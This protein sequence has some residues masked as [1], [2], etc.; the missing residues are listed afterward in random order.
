VIKDEEQQ[1][2]SRHTHKSNRILCFHRP[3]KTFWIILIV[4]LLVAAAI[5]G[6][7]GGSLARRHSTNT[8]TGPTDTAIE[9]ANS[10][11]PST[12]PSSPLP[13][14]P[15]TI[16]LPEQQLGD[17]SFLF[18]QSNSQE[19]FFVPLRPNTPLRPQGTGIRARRNTSLAALDTAPNHSGSIT[20]ASLYYVDVDGYLAEFIYNAYNGSWAP[21][22]PGL[23]V[24]S[25]LI[26]VLFVV[27]T[28]GIHLLGTDQPHGRSITRAQPTS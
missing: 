20:S 7:V 6:G 23:G 28:F 3:R 11:V 9:T 22:G 5:G 26:K 1:D 14:T 25:S 15:I 21:A 18:Y 12:A 16:S 13:D 2:L 10:F 8:I 19:L 4:V 17:E 27:T 24:S